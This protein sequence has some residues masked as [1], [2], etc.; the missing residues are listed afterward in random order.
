MRNRTAFR[1]ETRKERGKKG[2]EEINTGVTRLLP[3]NIQLGFCFLSVH[4]PAHRQEV[5]KKI[6]Y[7]LR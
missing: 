4:N 5:E 3:D 2:T 1:N 7:V 6:Q